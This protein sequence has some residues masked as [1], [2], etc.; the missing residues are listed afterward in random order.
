MAVAPCQHA[1]HDIGPMPQTNLFMACLMPANVQKVSPRRHL[2][3]MKNM[4][5]DLSAN[6]TLFQR[7]Y[8]ARLALTIQSHEKKGGV[9]GEATHDNGDREGRREAHLGKGIGH[10]QHDLPNLRTAHRIN[11]LILFSR[12]HTFDSSGLYQYF[13]LLSCK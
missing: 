4:C 8:Q 10:D 11:L 13:V 6:S 9:H 2:Q 12:L 7:P 5:D 1:G 3:R